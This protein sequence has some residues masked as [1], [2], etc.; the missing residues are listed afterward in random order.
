MPDVQPG[1]GRAMAAHQDGAAGAGVF[2]EVGILTATTRG[3][4][5]PQSAVQLNEGSHTGWVMTIDEKNIAHKREV[6]T[7]GV[8]DAKVQVLKGIKP[9]EG[10]VI[11][12]AYGL[13]DGTE[14]KRAK[15]GEK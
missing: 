5:V 15:S 1:D 11:Q 3:I 12:G 6:E 14:V 9:G 10:V 13:P 4:V 7:G 8:F 2:G